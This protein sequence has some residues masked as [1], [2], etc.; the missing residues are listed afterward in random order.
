M[1]ATITLIEMPTLS[2]SHTQPY[3]AC[4]LI[5]SYFA[6]SDQYKLSV[7]AIFCF[8][9]LNTAAENDVHDCS[10]Y[11]FSLQLRMVT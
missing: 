3:C 9:H 11:A 4:W 1:T 8:L 7:V 5:F 10:Y 6:P 2:Q